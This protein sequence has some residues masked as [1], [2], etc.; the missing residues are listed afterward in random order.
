MQIIDGKLLSSELLQKLTEQVDI[1]FHQTGITPCLHI[2]A[3]G[4]NPASQSY[5]RSKV[6]AGGKVGIKCV[7]STFPE[8]TRT[9]ELV[10]YIQSLNK[11]D[12]VHGVIIQLPLPPLIDTSKV[13]NTLSPKK[14]VDGFTFENQGKLLSGKP[15]FTPCTPMGIMYA[16]EKYQ[17][18]TKGA[19]AV[20]IGRSD[21][22]G[23]PIA[24]LLTQANA[25]VT[26]CHSYTTHLEKLTRQADIIVSAAGQPNLIHAYKIK[27]FATVIDVGINRVPDP[28]SEKGYKI[29]GDVNFSSTS[30]RAAYITPVPGGV[31]LLTVAML[32]KNTLKAAQLFKDEKL[33]ATNR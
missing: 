14:D 20:V 29:V 33:G 4:S 21:I 26:L 32:L 8:S 6:K 17:I 7:V 13:L 23:K 22:V 9:Q 18:N 5:I 28:K 16:L 31:G 3:V 25:T 24:A 10:D 2:V 12:S 30:A 19:H 11:D 1:F 27:N 15:L